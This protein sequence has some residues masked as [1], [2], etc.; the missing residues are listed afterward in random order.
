M[1]NGALSH[2]WGLPAAVRIHSRLAPLFLTHTEPVFARTHKD[3]NQLDICLPELLTVCSRQ[4]VANRAT[5]Y[6]AFLPCTF[7][8][9]PFLS[10]FGVLYGTPGCTGA[11][12]VAQTH[13]NLLSHP[14]E[15]WDDSHD[16]LCLCVCGGG[17]LFCCCC[18]CG[19]VKP[20]YVAQ[21]WSSWSSPPAS[22]PE[23]WGYR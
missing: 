3:H 18:C 20:C 22:A 12:C 19:E 6:S 10:L 23:G 9:A 5:V 13:G 21:T 11:Q 15:C 2:S 16:L 8:V 1:G 4:A 7:S 14:L 17:C